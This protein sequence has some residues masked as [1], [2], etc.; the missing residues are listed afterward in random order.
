MNAESNNTTDLIAIF[1]ASRTLPIGKKPPKG[2][3]AYL[4]WQLIDSKRQLGYSID[5]E[6]GRIIETMNILLGDFR[7]WAG[8]DDGNSYLDH[9]KLMA[10][11]NYIEQ[12]KDLR[13]FVIDRQGDTLEKLEALE[14]AEAAQKRL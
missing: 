8:V 9:V 10:I 5:E 11:E 4:V 2:T 1:K 13:Q 7:M 14:A 3:R 12:M 6:L